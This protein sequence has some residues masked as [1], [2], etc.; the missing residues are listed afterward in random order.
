MLRAQ[1]LLPSSTILLPRQ[2]L[3]LPWQAWTVELS[4][5]T[6]GVVDVVAR[7]ISCAAQA[8]RGCDS[9]CS[10]ARRCN[11]GFALLGAA[12]LLVLR[13]QRGGPALRLA[14]TCTAFVR[15]ARPYEPR[16]Q[17]HMPTL[18]LDIS[19]LNSRSISESVP[20]QL[21]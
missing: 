16:D 7:Q 14:V 13:R 20:Q 21:F 1:A 19:P 3:R 15:C 17:S 12:E 9:P 5:A 18:P 8:A 10:L 2:P 4:A 6:R 11:L